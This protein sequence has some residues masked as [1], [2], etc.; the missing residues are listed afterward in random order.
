L[1]S[2]LYADA[3]L[4]I[5]YIVISMFGWWNWLRGGAG[6]TELPTAGRRRE[7]ESCLGLEGL[8]PRPCSAQFYGA[9][10]IVPRPSAI[11]LQRRSLMWIGSTCR[12]AF[13]PTRRSRES[14]ENR[15][16]KSFIPQRA[17]VP[18]T[19]PA[20]MTIPSFGPNTR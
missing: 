17:F 20:K 18:V 5:V 10:L 9:S 2:E 11:A 4:Q 8:R 7:L 6:H 16:G 19:I 1:E 3:V 13:N 14:C 15:G 12:Y